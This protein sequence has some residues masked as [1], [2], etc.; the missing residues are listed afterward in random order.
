MTG[1]FSTIDP[2]S[3]H[4]SMLITPGNG[5]FFQRRLATGGATSQTI[6]KGEGLRLPIGSN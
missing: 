3:K 6:F 4:V 5:V 2:S 1:R